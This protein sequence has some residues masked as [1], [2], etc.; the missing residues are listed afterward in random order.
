MA[1]PVAATDPA[2]T[3]GRRLARGRR[4]GRHARGADGARHAG[5]RPRPGGRL[6]RCSPRCRTRARR[7]SRGPRARR[8]SPP[9][10]GRIVL[11]VDDVRA[12]VPYRGGVVVTT[13]RRLL[14]PGARRDRVRDRRR[15]WRTSAAPTG[16]AST[17]T[18]AVVVTATVYRCSPR[19]SAFVARLACGRRPG[20]RRR[21]AGEPTTMYARAPGRRARRPDV[22]QR[23]PARRLAARG[24]YRLVTGLGPPEAD[25]RPRSTVVDVSADGRWLA[26]DHQRRAPRRGRRRDRRRADRAGLP[27]GRS[28]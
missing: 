2:R 28:R 16:W 12:F 17:P 22:L 4:G 13:R 8:T 11:P 20:T 24:G 27:A 3:G 6:R 9:T 5:R 21:R 15:R 14:R 10:G 19:W 23:D 18:G 1:G 26:G 7:P 25:P